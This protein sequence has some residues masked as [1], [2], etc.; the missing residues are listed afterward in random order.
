MGRMRVI[1]VLGTGAIAKAH[2]SALAA[3]PE[4]RIHSV[5]GSDLGR[6][7]SVAALSPGAAAS[8]SVADVLADPAVDAVDICGST[9]DHARFTVE[10]ARSGKDVLVEK[11]AALSVAD[12]DEMVVA[13]EEAGRTLMVGQT[14]RFQP[15]VAALQRAIADGQIGRP[16]MLHI[17]WYGGYI[18]PGGWRSWQLDRSRSGGH[19][20]HNGPHLLDLAVWLTGRAPVRVFARSFSSWA[21]EMPVPDS[22]HMTVRFDDGS[23][24][25]FELSYALRRPGDALRRIVVAGDRG[26]LAQD[27]D[28]EPTLH[29]AAHTAAPPSTDG[30]MEAQLRHWVDTLHGADPIVRTS[31]V[32]A[33]LSAAIAAQQSLDERRPVALAEVLS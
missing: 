19:A 9:I 30:A 1:A 18:W 22:I 27:S 32:R 24:G 13:T 5:V 26:T 2:V 15:A 16:R 20:V 28:S 31:E 6:A 10:A 21:G 4:V 25:L 8:T 3:I 11:P 12:F 7:R 29:S 17:S 14:V 23:L 33:A